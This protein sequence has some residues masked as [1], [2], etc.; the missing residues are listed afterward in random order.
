MC[1]CVC[2]CVCSLHK[3]MS[4]KQEFEWRLHV[5]SRP[6]LLGPVLSGRGRPLPASLFRFTVRARPV[7]SSS[8]TPCQLVSIQSVRESYSLHCLRAR[9]PIIDQL[10]VVVAHSIASSVPGRFESFCSLELAC[11]VCSPW[12]NS[13]I[14]T[15]FSKSSGPRFDR[16][17]G[18]RM[19]KEKVLEG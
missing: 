5:T 19:I 9:A 12:A 8:P 2:V 3:C 4:F 10:P 16:L 1:V 14:V 6:K 17:D 13:K 7:R 15:S 18:S 11:Q